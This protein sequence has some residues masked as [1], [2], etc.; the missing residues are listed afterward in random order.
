MMLENDTF[1]NVCNTLA[2]IRGAFEDFVKLLP[3]NN[4]HRIAGIFE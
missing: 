1:D 3:L 4:V 2:A